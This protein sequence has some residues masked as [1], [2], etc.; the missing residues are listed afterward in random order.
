MN[1][2]TKVRG[3]HKHLLG[4]G[5]V[6]LEGGWGRGERGVA[7]VGVEAKKATRQVGRRVKGEHPTKKAKNSEGVAELVGVGWG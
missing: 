6:R 1:P 7:P 4:E 2:L 5:G 3:P